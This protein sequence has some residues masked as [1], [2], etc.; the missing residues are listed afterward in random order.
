M[1]YDLVCLFF[2]SMGICFIGKRHFH[3]FI[4]DYIEPRPGKFVDL[5]TGK[6]MGEHKGMNVL[7]GLNWL[8]L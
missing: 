5:E 8:N 2:Q 7:V 4:E 3:D 1:M 6:I